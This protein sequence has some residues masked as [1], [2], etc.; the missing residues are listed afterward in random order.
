MNLMISRIISES[1]FKRKIEE[2]KNVNKYNK[3]NKN[4]N[5]NIFIHFERLNSKN[6]KFIS[7]FILHNFQGDNFNYILIIHININF[8]IY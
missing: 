6:I 7:H 4:D 3:Y 5:K 8:N 1:E 2:K